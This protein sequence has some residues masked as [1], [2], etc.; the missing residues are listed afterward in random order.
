MNYNTAPAHSRI[1][2]EI[3]REDRV[4]FEYEVTGVDAV[5]SHNKAVHDMLEAGQYEDAIER[6]DIIAE[7]KVAATGLGKIR[8]SIGRRLGTVMTESEE[9]LVDYAARKQ[10]MPDFMH[11]SAENERELAK[12]SLR[13]TR[14]ELRGIN[15]VLYANSSVEDDLDQSAPAFL[16]TAKDTAGE[17]VTW[18]SW[19]ADTASDEQLLNFLQ[20]H[21]TRHAEL[22]A[23]PEAKQQIEVLKQGYKDRLEQGIQEGWVSQAARSAIKKLD[24]TRIH[25]GDAF[26]LLAHKL[27]GY[28]INGT[29]YAIVDSLQNISTTYHEL[30]HTTFSYGATWRNEA[31]T[32]HLAQVMMSGQ[33]EVVDPHARESNSEAYTEERMLL[34]IVLSKGAHK[35][36]VELGLRAYTGSEVDKQKFEE[37]LC[38]SWEHVLPEGVSVLE[39]IDQHIDKMQA[40]YISAAESGD[41][42]DV[43]SA[44]LSAALLNTA[45]MLTVAPELIFGKKEERSVQQILSSETVAVSGS[46]RELVSLAVKK[47]MLAGEDSTKTPK[48]SKSRHEQDIDPSVRREIRKLSEKGLT[49]KQVFRRLAREYHTD[50]NGTD[51]GSTHHKLADLSRWNERVSKEEQRAKGK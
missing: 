16:K 23:S 7:N 50:V 14:K 39:S 31:F 8:G 27:K 40:W 32:E 15:E 42:T 21:T 41:L 43:K 37:A 13:V 35:V 17:G 24:N 49:N 11:K 44:A 10:L 47:G 46:F 34:G 12:N 19:L 9:A 29:N 28:Q 30:H 4:R 1:P 5:N 25:A 26:D 45:G 2:Q 36:P 20:W 6:A 18:Q 22:A 38:R 3:P 48:S 51:D 33:P